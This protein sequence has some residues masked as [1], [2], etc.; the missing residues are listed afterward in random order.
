MFES[1][2]KFTAVIGGLLLTLWL[3][4]LVK[5]AS[6]GSIFNRRRK[7]GERKI[8]RPEKDWRTVPAMGISAPCC[9]EWLTFTPYD[10]LCLDRQVSDGERREVCCGYCHAP[11]EF[12]ARRG[13][14]GLV[15]ERVAVKA[16]VRST[17]ARR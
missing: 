9:G 11:L 15:I 10:L 5:I 2:I 1:T 8:P 12:H 13:P 4:E 14:Q 6:L 7:R 3:F 16:R 17:E